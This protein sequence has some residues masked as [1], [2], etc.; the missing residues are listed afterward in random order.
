[1][2]QKLLDLINWTIKEKVSYIT[3]TLEEVKAI[4]KYL[5]AID[6]LKRQNDGATISQEE[7]DLLKEVE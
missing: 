1:M 4:Q 6:I 5:K 7:D 3:L 2:K